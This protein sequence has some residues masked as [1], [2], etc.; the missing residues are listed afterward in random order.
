MRLMGLG[1]HF[2][3]FVA[4]LFVAADAV[5]AKPKAALLPL[6]P[7]RIPEGIVGIMNDLLAAE[8]DAAGRYQVIG[9]DD[10]N[11]MLGFEKMKEATGCTEV[12]CAAE[13]GG[14]LGVNFLIFG[15]VG[16][17]ADELFVALTLIDIQ[18][19]AVVSRGRAM[20]ADD[21]HNYRR[22]IQV[23]V[24]DLLKL[25]VPQATEAA[26]TSRPHSGPTSPSIFRIETMESDRS[27]NVTLVGSDGFA[28]SCA[29][30]V[31]LTQACT[32]E[33]VAPGEASLTA[34]SSELG[35]YRRSVDAE[36]DG[37]LVVLTLRKFPGLA[38][39]SFWGVGGGLALFGGMMAI[40]GY[41]ADVRGLRVAAFTLAGIGTAFGVAG[42]FLGDMVWGSERTSDL[43]HASA[44]QTSDAAPIGLVL[45]PNMVGVHG[46]F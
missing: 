7:T 8:L 39:I 4:M 14:A 41:V 32:I 2:L 27:F 24:A 6:T 20:V 21:E 46:S 25:K 33:G 43:P 44:G 36:E 31:T 1:K 17:L 15:K 29:E 35:S 40:P 26:V 16:K 3:L 37:E 19:P 12:T 5:G 30:P 18:K 22:A 34:T 10:I 9:T 13:I 38:K 11:A 28:H 45:A 42:F 23:A